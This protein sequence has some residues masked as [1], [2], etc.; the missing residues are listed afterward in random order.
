MLDSLHHLLLIAEHGSFTAA[1]R[2]AH[3]SQPALTA[4]IHRLEEAMGGRLLDRHAR[5]ATPTAAGMALLPHARA[6]LAAVEAGRQAVAEIE[7]LARG[8]VRIGG[9]ATACTWLLPP[10]LAEF[11]RAHPDIDI[12]VRETFSPAVR[13]DVRAG[14]LDLG[15]TQGL[16]ETPGLVEE[17]WRQDPLVMVASPDVAERLRSRVPPGAP[18]VT[19]AAGSA[20]RG[21][22]DQHRPDLQVTMELASIAAVKGHVRAGL[23]VALLPQATVQD[24][25][26]LGHLVVLHDSGIPAARQLSLVHAGLDRLSPAATALREVLLS[27]VA[28]APR[29]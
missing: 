5:G 17:P 15:I 25:L 10:L 11:H 9:G 3:L 2:H 23:G 19:F 18:V 6:A 13:D 7:G 28:T 27:A 1:S 14:L 22:L 4:S 29:R 21:L 26:D 24:D 16:T 8:R 12:R 20:L